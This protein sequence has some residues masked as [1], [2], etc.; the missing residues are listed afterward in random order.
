MPELRL[1]PILN[2][3]VIIA[4]NR[5]KR[6]GALVIDPT[7]SVPGMPGDSPSVCPF[8]PSNERETPGEVYALRNAPG[9]PNTPGW[10]VRIVPNK[11]PALLPEAD[12]SVNRGT[13][14]TGLLRTTPPFV[15][16]PALGIHEVIID[17]PRHVTT[18][19]ELTD[20]EFADSLAAVRRRLSALRSRPDLRHAL[21]FKNVGRA[22]GATREHMHSQL[23]ATPR[24]APLVEEELLGAESFFAC[25]GQCVFCRMID[26]EFAGGERIVCQ[27]PRF[28][29]VCPFASRFPYEI[30]I[31][32][33]HHSSHFESIVEED[34]D[35]LAKL[36]RG[37]IAKIERLSRSVAYNLV[38]HSGPF[39]SLAI[40][41]YHWHIEVLPRLTIPAGFEW[42]SG[43]AV[44]PVSPESA[45]AALRLDGDFW[46]R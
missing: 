6:P 8:C 41:H 32:P 1:D 2:R 7:Q 16:S 43:C 23:M 31:L 25:H 14:V 24:I 46:S 26:L 36:A 30:C 28:V 5:A 39:D 20:A 3:W 9:E 35:E 22:S 11:Y 21:V 27:S 18:V 44:N 15:S 10:S 17:T 42:G 13:N 45:A 34:L 38:L 4:E 12:I 19:G 40:E 33:R 29:I 37:A